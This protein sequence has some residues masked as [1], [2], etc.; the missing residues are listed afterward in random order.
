MLNNPASGFKFNI[1][2]VN[3]NDYSQI[4]ML[5]LSANANNNTRKTLQLN[6][7]PYK[8]PVDK[9]FIAFQ[10][11][12]WVG[13]NSTLGI[14]GEGT[15]YLIGGNFI[16]I[17]ETGVVYAIGD[18][19]WHVDPDG[20]RRGYLCKAAHTAGDLD[21]EPGVGTVE[22]T[23][24]EAADSEIVDG[25]IKKA[26]LRFSTGTNLPFITDCIGIFGNNRFINASATSSSYFMAGSVLYG[27]EID[28]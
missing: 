14:I 18:T 9:V 24:W 4:K 1:G 12:L 3:F 10:G 26:V 27:I 28:A 8:V 2:G 22:G 21:D 19:V 11:S 20:Y 5:V 7:K 23:Y 17:W 16:G 13:D 6:G 25:A 15:T